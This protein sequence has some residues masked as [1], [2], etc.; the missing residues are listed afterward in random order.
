MNDIE[1]IF[2]KIEDKNNLL[3]TNALALNEGFTWDIPIIYGESKQGRFWLYA[4]E[5]TP[6]PHG[7]DFV[8]SVEYEKKS[9]FRKRTIKCHTHRHPQSIEEAVEDV[10]K[11][12]MGHHPI[13][14]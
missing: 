7:V 5:D 14:K 8:F 3:L 10:E 13:M 1:L 4:D 2:E 11:F 9:W 12:M 6:D